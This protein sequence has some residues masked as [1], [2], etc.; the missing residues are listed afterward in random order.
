MNNNLSI[1]IITQND[2]M[3]SGCFDVEKVVAICEETFVEYFN[4]EVLF[5]D[6][7]SVIFNEKTQDR[8][9]CL[10][11]GLIKKQVYGMKWVSV[12]PENP[13]KRGVPNL[14]AVILLSEMQSGFPVAFME[15]S[16][17][18]NLRTAAVGAVGAKYFARPEAKT[19]GFIGAG[20]QAKTHLL[21]M[22][23]VLKKL[24][25]CRVASR[26]HQSELQF[27]EDMRKFYP[28]ME[29]VTCNSD[30]SKAADSDVV[31]TAISG[32]EKI[33]QAEWINPGTFYCH[34]GG[35]EDDFGVAKKADKIVCDDWNMVKHRT[36]T[37][38]QM[39]KQG[40]LR[41]ED[42]Y[43]NLYEVVAGKKTGRE[44]D[45]EFVYFNSV[46]MSYLDVAIANWMYK[47][48]CE[49]KLGQDI[50]FKNRQCLNYNKCLGIEKRKK[51]D[52]IST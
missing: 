22:K 31:V 23:S 25:V 41:D 11:A 37:I 28:D 44:S 8:I 45:K 5:P 9:N 21:T 4:G 18:S 42:I 39:Y 24:R 13:H 35:L 30:Y 14:T 34:V 27:V 15:G 16:L 48:V 12:F 38:S 7:V 26:T 2:L 46:G 52:I 47:K 32:Q 29:F 20:E 51:C 17:C 50:A 19:I 3:E 43:A 36:Q 6:K 33:L 10:S 40:L 1:K 49:R